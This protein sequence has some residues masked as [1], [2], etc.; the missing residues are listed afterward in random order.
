MSKQDILIQKLREYFEKRD[1]ILMA[2]IF[3]SYVKEQ[4]TSESDFDI[5]VYFKPKGNILEW[6]ET[7]IYSDEDRIWGDVEKITGM[8]TDFV[9]MN[10][11]PS[12]LAYSII[13]EGLPII[14]KNR[15]LYLRFFLMI[16]SA[17]EYFRDFTK[18][19]WEIKQRS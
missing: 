1:D 11:A 4:Q 15:A 9:V 17:A 8:R 12:T 6:E 7:D 13:Q 2:F 14:I 18:D 5:A 10:R 3:G 16:S 19:F